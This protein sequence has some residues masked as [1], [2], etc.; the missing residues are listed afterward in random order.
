MA[1]I[2]ELRRYSPSRP[3]PQIAKTMEVERNMVRS[4]ISSEVLQPVTNLN[5]SLLRC[6]LLLSFM[7]TA[8]Y[9]AA[10]PDHWVGTWAAAT[11]PAPARPVPPNGVAPAASQVPPSATG[12]AQGPATAQ[13]SPPAAANIAAPPARFAGPAYGAADTTYREI[14][15]VSLGG[16]MVRVVFTNEFGTDPLTIGAAHV[17]VSEGGS[18]INLVSAGGLTFGGRPSVII[19]PGAVIVSDPVTMKLAAGADLA[20][21]FLLP[22]QPVKIASVHGFANQTSYTVPGNAVGAKTLEAPREIA[23]WPFLKSVDV[24]VSAASA[25]IVAFGD[26]IT[27]GTGSAKNTNTRWPDVFARRLQADKK[28]ADLSVLNE[29]IGGNRILHDG[30]GPNA[31]A[32]FDRDVLAQAG[33]KYVIMLEAINDIGHSQDPVKPYDVITADD[34]IMGYTQLAERA[35]TH[36][37]KFYA[38]TVLPYGGAKYASPSGDVMRQAVNKWI[39]T[40]NLIDGFIDMEKATQDPAN[41]TMYLP[42]ND[43]GDHLH[44]STAGHKAMADSIDLKLFESK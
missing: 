10:P 36:G 28:T 1:T 44:P 21:S 15:H 8:A 40:T 39:R 26:S 31:L 5:R 23:S 27:D 2:R 22:E 37:I 29:G 19:P 43:M 42:A 12:P 11:V 33:V 30:T 38:A 35:H 34:L 7:A 20:V 17:A 16:P 13:L 41:P 25:A 9:A 4:K 6:L 18:S 3:R 24:E 32:R 14:V